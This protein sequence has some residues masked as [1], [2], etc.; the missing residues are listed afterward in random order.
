MAPAPVPSSPVPLDGTV[1]STV[2]QSIPTSTPSPQPFETSAG[3][4]L[5]WNLLIGSALGALIIFTIGCLCSAYRRK[6]AAAVPTSD[7]LEVVRRKPERTPTL[8]RYRSREEQE[9]MEEGIADFGGRE[10]PVRPPSYVGLDEYSVI[11][12]HADGSS[13]SGTGTSFLE[14]QDLAE[15]SGAQFDTQ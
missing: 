11:T 2:A 14:S 13:T 9:E 8:P 12:I 6:R 15:L 4:D 1:F 5:R 7:Q 3:F 10:S